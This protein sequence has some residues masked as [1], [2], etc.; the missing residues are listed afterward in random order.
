M[1]YLLSFKLSWP[2]KKYI[3][4]FYF[5]SFKHVSNTCKNTLRAQDIAKALLFL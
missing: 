5:S 3:Q 1:V 2:Y 4:L